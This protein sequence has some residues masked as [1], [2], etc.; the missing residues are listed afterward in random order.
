MD[1]QEFGTVKDLVEAMGLMEMDAYLHIKKG[2]G[3]PGVLAIGGIND[4][5]VPIWQPAKFV[6]GLQEAN[7]SDKPILLQVNYNSGHGSEEK[8]VIYNNLANQFAFALWQ[9][10]HKDCQPFQHKR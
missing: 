7:S 6:A 2:E 10:G 9:A 1:A 5:R 4:T 8:F 3:Y